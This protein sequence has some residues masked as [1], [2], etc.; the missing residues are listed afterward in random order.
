LF[1]QLKLANPSVSILEASKAA[2]GNEAEVAAARRT[3]QIGNLGVVDQLD[4]PVAMRT[5]HVKRPGHG[6]V[7]GFKKFLHSVAV[8][9]KVA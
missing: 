5:P 6:I 3:T 2:G 4:P 7:E 8:A 1:H 9:K